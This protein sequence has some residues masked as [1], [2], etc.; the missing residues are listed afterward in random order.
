MDVTAEVIGHTEQSLLASSVRSINGAYGAGCTTRSGPW[1]LRVAGADALTNPPLSVLRN[2]GACT[3]TI[4]SLVTS[5]SETH[6]STPAFEVMTSYQASAVPFKRT[7]VTTFLANAKVDTTTFANNFVLTVIFSSDLT[8]SSATVPST[9]AITAFTK[10]EL[11]TLIN[12]RCYPCHITGAPAGMSLANDFTVQTVGVT[13]TEAAPMKRIQAGS[14][15][16]SYLFHKI[17]GTQLSVG[18]SGVRM[19]KSGPPYLSDLEIERIGKYID[20]L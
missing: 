17:S 16:N 14:R 12:A 4:S 13:S 9:K 1:S 11:Q 6:M 18:G 2:N 20:G 7:G 5:A 10:A 3:L 8:T 15:A 19:P